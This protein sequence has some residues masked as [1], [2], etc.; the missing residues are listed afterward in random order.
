V[1]LPVFGV[2]EDPG[3]NFMELLR[4]LKVHPFEDLLKEAPAGVPIEMRHATTIL[5][6]KFADGVVV[7]GDR[8]ATEANRIAHSAIQ[9]VFP[10]DSHSAIAIAGVAGVAS[11]LVRLF[12]TQVAHFEKVEGTSLSLEGK[13]NQLAQMIRSN[14]ELAFRGLVVVP[15][16]AGYDRKRGVGRIFSFDVV[17]GKYEEFDYH[18]SGSGGRDAQMVLKLGTRRTLGEHEAIELALRALV[19]AA[20]E[21]SATGGPDLARGIFPNVVKVTASGYEEIATDTLREIT[22]SLVSERFASR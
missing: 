10:V 5:A 17:G 11:E 2:H 3:P 12:Q 14:L 16:F 8:R 6:F 13:A 22:E 20:E 9:K 7:A 1:N 21:D 18:A 19:A 4:K 15:I